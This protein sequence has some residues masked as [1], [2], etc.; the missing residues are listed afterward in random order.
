MRR[1]VNAFFTS[2]EV[3]IL[4]RPPCG[5]LAQFG[6]SGKLLTLRSG[7]QIPH[8]PPYR[9]I[10]QRQKT[11]LII[12]QSES[13][14][15]YSYHMPIQFNWQRNALVM[16]RLRVQFLLSAP[17]SWVYVAIQRE[18]INKSM[19]AGTMKQIKVLLYNNIKKC[20]NLYVNKIRKDIQEEINMLKLWQKKS[21]S[22]Y[23]CKS[24]YMSDRF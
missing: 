4:L 24:N 16:R 9:S 7:V 11:R 17:D 10:L 2:S 21:R 1:T 22:Q 15:R 3:Q 20:Y 13:D 8:L 23:K 12:A 14:S 18:S 6:Q 19:Q 5:S